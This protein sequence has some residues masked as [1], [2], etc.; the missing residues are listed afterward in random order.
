VAETLSFSGGSFTAGNLDVPGTNDVVVQ[1]AEGGAFVLASEDGSAVV[2]LGLEGDDDAQNLIFA[3]DTPTAVVG[4]TANLGGGD[5]TL[6]IGGKVKDGSSIRMQSGDDSVVTEGTVR[7]S[8]I[9][10]NAGN[11]ETI[12]NSNSEFVARDSS[13]GMGQGDDALVFGGSVQSVQTNLGTG[14]DSVEFQG[15]ILGAKLNLGGSGGTSDGEADVIR[16]SAD[17]SIEGFVITGAD[18]NDTL[19]IG[20]T[21]YNYDSANNLWVNATNSGDTRNFS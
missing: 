15:N 14:A 7:D 16:I 2:N 10:T 13:I 4:L 9:R 11:D 1:Q 5:D 18:E 17:A 8:Q 19:F 20:T 21:Q 6:V 3:S 12:L